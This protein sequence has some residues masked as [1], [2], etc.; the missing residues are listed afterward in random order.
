MSSPENESLDFIRSIVADDLAS[1]KHSTIVTRFP[2]EPNGFLHIGH[3]KAI[4]LDFGLA[5]ENGGRCHLRFD[6]T[7][8]S[9]EEDLYVQ[10]IRE[11]VRWLGF[12][13][14]DNEFYASNYFEQLYDWAV[15]LIEKGLAYVCDLDGEQMRTYRGTLTEPG[16]DSPFRTRG[17]EENMDLFARMRAGEFPAGARV[18]R[19]KVDMAHPN[20]NMRD[21]VMY[22]IMHVHHHRTGD[23]W[24][25][26]PTYDYTHGQSDSLEGITHSL[27]TL[28]FEAHR[29]LYE[30]FIEKL[31]IFPSRQIE[32]ARLNLNYTV[33][34]KRKLLQLVEEKHV[35]GWDDPRLPTLSGMRRRGYPPAAIRRFCKEIGLGKRENVIEMAKLENC[36]R[37]ELNRTAPRHMCVLRPLKVIIDNYPEDLVEEMDA[38]NNPEDPE[39]GKR[40]VPFSRELYIEA[41]DFLEDPPKKFFRLGPGREVRLRYGYFVTCV[42]FEKDEDGNITELHCTYD[43][44]T[45]GGN[46]PD[47]RRVKGTIHWVSAAHALDVELRLYD[48]L[49]TEATPEAGDFLDAI[50]PDS[51]EILSGA[52]A[53]PGLRSSP[54]GYSCQFER[55]GYFCVDPDSSDDK[56][57]FNRTTGLRDRWAKMQKKAKM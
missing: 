19:A 7:N 56:L 31:G 46:A 23:A 29:P 28:E 20:L 38:V 25:I 10:A 18:L 5:A 22:R 50:N 14:G 21:P 1:G 30:W 26:Y 37:E 32:F 33:M 15:S 24:C 48:H 39:A 13:W 55:T 47:G 11:D 9:K 42:G 3:A 34:S 12:D 36:I 52:K 40:K 43:P 53:E 16:T 45:R 8:P 49:F 6:D 27:C 54:A 51:V 57:V 2:P 35:N 17:V 41:S 4:C 44:E